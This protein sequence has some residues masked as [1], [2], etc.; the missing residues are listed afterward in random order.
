[1]T[2]ASSLV[3]AVSSSSRSRTVV[4]IEVVLGRCAVFFLT[5]FLDHR[6]PP[7]GIHAL[8]FRCAALRES[9][10]EVRI[11]KVFLKSE[12]CIGRMHGNQGAIA[13]IEL[14]IGRLLASQSDQYALSRAL[15]VQLGQQT[16]V[17]RHLSKP[18]RAFRTTMSLRI[19]AVS[20]LPRIELHRAQF[21]GFQELS[22]RF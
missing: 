4:L 9:Y 6:S 8:K 22:T 14:F 11:L 15:I 17:P 3:S 20:W 18:A 7:G 5:R 1:M 19:R 21:V 16:Q 10:R 2:K 13:G 12:G